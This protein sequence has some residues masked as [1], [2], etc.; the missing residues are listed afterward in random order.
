MYEQIFEYFG[1][2]FVI[3]GHSFGAYLVSMF[4]IRNDIRRFCVKDIILLSPIGMNRRKKKS[5][6]AIWY[7][8][9]E[10]IWKMRSTPFDVLRALDKVHLGKIAF[11]KYFDTYFKTD[12]GYHG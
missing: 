10:L 1:K 2:G 7:G 12:P 6:W 8:I 5:K 11:G 9:R 3:I 4:C